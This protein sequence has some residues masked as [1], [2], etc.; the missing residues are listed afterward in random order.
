MS[1]LQNNQNQCLSPI[2]VGSLQVIAAA[3]CWGTLGIFSTQLGKLGL[4][5]FQITTLRIVTAGLLALVLLPKLLAII[6]TLSAKQWLSLGLQSLIGVLGMTLC[7][8]FAV[9]Q[10]GVSMAVALLCCIGGRFSVP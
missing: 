5:S 4:N 2:L 1:I 7:Y 3:I 8:F 10:V 6:K 9:Q